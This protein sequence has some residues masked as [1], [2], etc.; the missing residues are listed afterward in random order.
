MEGDRLSVYPVFESLDIGNV[1]KLRPSPLREPSFALDVHL[2]KLAGYL[3]LTGFRADY[4]NFWDDADLVSYAAEEE[5]IVL[6]R[7][8]GLLKRNAVSRGMFVYNTDPIEQ[9]REICR[10]MDLYSKIKPFIRCLSCGDILDPVE[11]N[12]SHFMEIKSRIPE[13]V[14]S[15]CREFSICP[16]CGKIY[17]EGSHIKRLKSIVEI[18][19]EDAKS[20]GP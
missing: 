16:G 12:S 9:I 6:S 18:L 5:L 10:R 4:N 14:L 13:G 8:R 7:D 3:R 20:P 1:T 15:W 17:W 2:G 19:K 11:Y